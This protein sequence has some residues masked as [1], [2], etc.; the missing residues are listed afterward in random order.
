MSEKELCVMPDCAIE[1]IQSLT[2]ERDA[3]K[4]AYNFLNDNCGC[5]PEVYDHV[6]KLLEKYPDKQALTKGNDN[7]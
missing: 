1:Q 7:E 4:E 5:Y 6:N 2:A 3:Y